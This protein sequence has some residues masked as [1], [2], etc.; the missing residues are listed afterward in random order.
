MVTPPWGPYSKLLALEPARRV[1]LGHEAL[2]VDAKLA[3]FDHGGVVDRDE[4]RRV[5]HHGEAEVRRD[6]RERHRAQHV[7]QREM[8]EG[9]VLRIADDQY[10]VAGAREALV[11]EGVVA[12]LHFVGQGRAD[13]HPQVLLL[14]LDDAAGGVAN[15]RSHGRSRD[16]L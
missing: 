8:R 7:A 5:G 11:G 1:L 4:V 14:Q 13:A 2:G 12:L 9:V 15:T 3:G 6:T 10:A 16:T